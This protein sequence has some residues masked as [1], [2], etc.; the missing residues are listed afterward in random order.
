MF[1]ANPPV[2]DCARVLTPFA[3]HVGRKQVLSL[4]RGILQFIAGRLLEITRVPPKTKLR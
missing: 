4:D 3:D 2:R 1:C